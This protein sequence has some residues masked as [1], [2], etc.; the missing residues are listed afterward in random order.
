[1]TVS[2]PGPRFPGR[3]NSVEEK[4]GDAGRRVV[5]AYHALLAHVAQAKGG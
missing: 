4:R 3:T 2:L 5:E 1:M